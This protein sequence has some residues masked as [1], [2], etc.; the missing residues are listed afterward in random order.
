MNRK[1]WL[2][3]SLVI[4]STIS[5]AVEGLYYQRDMP[6]S[7]AAA[8][9]AALVSSFLIAL[10]IDV[11]SKGRPQVGRC[12]DYGFFVYVSW[13]LYLPWYLQRTR[14][15]VG[16]LMYAG[17]GVPFLLGYFVQWSIYYWYRL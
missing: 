16:L 15:G 3:G 8:D 7:P 10:W 11:D 2:I 12:F 5:A 17:F 1:I 14:G 4:V 6:S 9:L 13:P